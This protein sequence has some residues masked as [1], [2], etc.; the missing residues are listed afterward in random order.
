VYTQLC[1]HH[2]N[3]QLPPLSISTLSANSLLSIAD[4]SLA[5]RLSSNSNDFDNATSQIEPSDDVLTT[6]IIVLRMPM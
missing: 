5:Q 3:E 1:T 4:I 6:L 2:G